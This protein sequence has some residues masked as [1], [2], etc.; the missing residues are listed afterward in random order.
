MAATVTLSTTTLSRTIGSGDS[1][2]VLGS[3]TNVQPGLR[4]FI[5]LELLAVERLTGIGNEVIVRR[6]VDGTASTRH[7]SSAPIYIG[8]ADQFYSRPPEGLPAPSQRVNPHI[9]VNAGQIWWVVGDEVGAGA[10]ARKWVPSLTNI[11]PGALGVRVTSVGV[12]PDG[13]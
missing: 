11:Q 2:I 6:G 12:D 1:S 13:D 8:R 9:D 3:L 5:D 4:L 7:G 10:D